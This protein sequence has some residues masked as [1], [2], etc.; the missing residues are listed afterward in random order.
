MA[1]CGL[2]VMEDQLSVLCTRWSQDSNSNPEVDVD[3]PIIGTSIARQIVYLKMAG[4]DFKHNLYFHLWK[5][6]N[7]LAAK[8]NCKVSNQYDGIQNVQKHVPQLTGM[9]QV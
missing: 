4:W 8:Y 1:V 5:R 3:L 7:H 9:I 6:M 2:Q